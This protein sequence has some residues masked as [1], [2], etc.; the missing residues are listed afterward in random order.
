MCEANHCTKAER[1]G[2]SVLQLVVSF[3]CLSFTYCYNLEN[4]KKGSSMFNHYLSM[5][6]WTAVSSLFSKKKK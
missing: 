6:G 1:A 4:I 3:F 2:K 5:V